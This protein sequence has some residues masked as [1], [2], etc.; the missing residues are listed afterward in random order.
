LLGTNKH[1]PSPKCLAANDQE[2]EREDAAL[3][4]CDAVSSNLV[5]PDPEYEDTSARSFET[6]R[7]MTRFTAVRTPNLTNEAKFSELGG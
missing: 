5:L 2:R 7:S 4:A 1:S 3:L 6:V